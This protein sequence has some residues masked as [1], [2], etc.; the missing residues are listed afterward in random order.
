MDQ[1]KPSD[2][3]QK[4]EDVKPTQTLN[5]KDDDEYVDIEHDDIEMHD[6]EDGDEKHASDDLELQRFGGN[7][8]DVGDEDE[9]SDEDHDHMAHH[10]LLSMLTGRL[11]QRRRGST[12]KYDHLHPENQVLSVANVDECTKL[13]A[14]NFPEHER[15]PREKVR[16]LLPDSRTI[17]SNRMLNLTLIHSLF[18]DYHDVQN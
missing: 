15:A 14:Q 4:S 10:P 1:E 6:G 7:L 8:D 2:Q 5:Q 17:Q 9:E 3:N 18:I 12:H 13:E 11:G 16:R